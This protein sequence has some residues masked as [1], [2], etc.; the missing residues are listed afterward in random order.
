MTSTGC[1]MGKRN[2]KVYEV[3]GIAADFIGE[4]STYRITLDPT[5]LRNFRE[6]FATQ[7]DV[8]IRNLMNKLTEAKDDILFKI[9]TLS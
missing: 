5:N 2:I 6:I 3:E 9:I 8:K 1:T 7:D 4:N